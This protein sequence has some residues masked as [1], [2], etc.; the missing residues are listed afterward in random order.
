MFWLGKSLLQF[1]VTQISVYFY[2]VQ[3]K[4]GIENLVLA[5]RQSPWTLKSFSLNKT[6]LLNAWKGFHLCSEDDKSNLLRKKSHLGTFIHQVAISGGL[7]REIVFDGFNGGGGITLYYLFTLEICV[8]TK[9]IRPS[10]L[11]TFF[12]FCQESEITKYKM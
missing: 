1:D 2:S 11:L 5:M 10:N 7:E 4:Q 12:W 3:T 6:I 8:C 9:K